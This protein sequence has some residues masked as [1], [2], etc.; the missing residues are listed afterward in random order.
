MNGVTWAAI[1]GILGGMV[2]LLVFVVV[3]G[4]M[5]RRSQRKRHRRRMIEKTRSPTMNDDGFK[6]NTPNV[7]A[8]AGSVQLEVLRGGNPG[9][10]SPG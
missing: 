8:I 10:R 2:F 6:S 3:L 5:M 9:S 4:Y 7:D 1:G